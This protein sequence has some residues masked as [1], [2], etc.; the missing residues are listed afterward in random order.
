V[1]NMH[2]G[3]P[4][5]IAMTWTCAAPRVELGRTDGRVTAGDGKAAASSGRE[6]IRTETDRD[7]WK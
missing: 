1:R 7:G 4:V 2:G 3:R 6:A 5:W